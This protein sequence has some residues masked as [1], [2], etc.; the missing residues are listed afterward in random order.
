[1]HPNGCFFIGLSMKRWLLL[2]LLLP[3]QALAFESKT[4]SWTDPTEFTDG[5]PLDADADILEY[6]L[7]CDAGP[8]SRYHI[9]NAPGLTIWTSP[10]GAFPV[11][12]YNC[13]IIAVVDGASSDPSNTVTFTIDPSKPNAPTDFKIVITINIQ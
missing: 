13:H 11:G 1:M 5:A 7:E 3:I 10:D 8:E 4:F 2:L 6:H 9:T 12:T